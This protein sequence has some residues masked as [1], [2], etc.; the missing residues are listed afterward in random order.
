MKLIS[1]FIL[2]LLLLLNTPETSNIKLVIRNIDPAQGN[3]QIAIFNSEDDFLKKGSE[4]RIAVVPVSGSQTS[5]TF[6]DLPLGDYA[7]SLYHDVN[8]D[9]KCNRNWIGIPTE[10]YAFSN[11]YH[12]VLKAPSFD[13]TRIRLRKDTTLYLDLIY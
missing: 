4:Y 5:Y 10:G 8:K 1:N 2:G 6:K 13:D 12:P 9:D 7:I 3:L 11:N